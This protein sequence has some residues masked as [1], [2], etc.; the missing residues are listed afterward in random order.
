MMKYTVERKTRLQRK[1]DRKD[2]PIE[3]IKPAT[4]SRYAAAVC[5]FFQY[6]SMF[7]IP[8]PTSGYSLDSVV[9]KWVLYMYQEGEPA[10]TTGDGLSGLQ[11]FLPSVRRSLNGS[12]RVFKA[13]R[14]HELPAQAPPF[15]E[16]ICDALVGL[17]LQ[18]GL[19]GL[20]AAIAVGY[21]CCLRSGEIFALLCEHVI[22]DEKAGAV[23]LPKTKKGI[24]DCV[25]IECSRVAALCFRRV[26]RLQPGE[27]FMGLTPQK[28][29]SV[30][31]ELLHVLNLQRF[32]FRWYSIRRGGATSQFRAHGQM[33]KI[34][35]RGRWESSR[36][37]RLYLTDGVAAMTSVQLSDEERSACSALAKLW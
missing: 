30:L 26:V 36:T 20:A 34:L 35:V 31:K 18:V 33:E 17:A 1:I 12:W 22:C 24:R 3:I 32:E 21:H 23:V 15:P 5:L 8:M 29:R 14:A 27:S 37:A 6:M 11:H 7:A 13:W 28:A 16:L 2:A 25:S 10:G 4:L 9:T 19:L